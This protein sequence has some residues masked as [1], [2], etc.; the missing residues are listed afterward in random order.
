MDLFEYSYL[1]TQKYKITLHHFFS[2]CYLNFT[3]HLLYS[4]LGYY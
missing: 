1:E 2:T 3:L 4:V